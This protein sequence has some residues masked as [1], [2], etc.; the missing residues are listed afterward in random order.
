MKMSMHVS[1]IYMIFLISA[2]KPY[3]IASAERAFFATKFLSQKC[4]V[5]LPT[6]DHY[7]GDWRF[8]HANSVRK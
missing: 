5:S 3:A 1:S 4:N 8:S 6:P 7:W 2:C